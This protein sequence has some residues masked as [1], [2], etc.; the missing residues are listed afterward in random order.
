MT[1]NPNCSKVQPVCSHIQ[2]VA[3]RYHV[4]TKA[5]NMAMPEAVRCCVSSVHMFCPGVSPNIEG[6]QASGKKHMVRGAEVAAKTYRLF[7]RG[8]SFVKWRMLGWI[9]DVVPTSDVKARFWTTLTL[10][11][12]RCLPSHPGP[13]RHVTS[14]DFRSP[15]LKGSDL[16][17][18]RTQEGKPVPASSHLGLLCISS[19]MNND[20]LPARL[21][22]KSRPLGFK[23]QP[24]LATVQARP[25]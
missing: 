4:W 23:R 3:V 17:G 20:S 21:L 13:P 10:S 18:F 9:M 24:L 19:L 1:R 25:G 15:Q 2:P 7:G 11:E 14:R 22:L 12:T 8:C 16:T 5:T 6:V